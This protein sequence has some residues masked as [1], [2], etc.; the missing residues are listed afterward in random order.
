MAH[1]KALLHFAD[2]AGT[3]DQM[4]IEISKAHFEDLFYASGPRFGCGKNSRT[5]MG[6]V[7]L[8]V[9][10]MAIIISVTDLETGE[11]L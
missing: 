6:A 9:Q 4:T 1:T 5:K 8:L 7:R 2:R 10:D 11:P 3:E